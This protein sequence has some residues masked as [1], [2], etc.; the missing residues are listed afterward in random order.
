MRRRTNSERTIFKGAFLPHGSSNNTPD[1]A[2]IWAVRR[3]QTTD[4]VQSLTLY[5]FDAKDGTDLCEADAVP[6]Q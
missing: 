2:I 6:G 3:P 5:A 1:S 4:K